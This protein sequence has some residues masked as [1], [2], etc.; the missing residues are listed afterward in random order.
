MPFPTPPAGAEQAVQE[1]P[2]VDGVLFDIDETLVDLEQAMGRTLQ[3]IPD[4][5]LDHLS[6]DDW[7]RYKALYTGDPQRHYDRFLAGELTFEE[8][9]V[10][11]I[12]HA[13]AG[14][15]REPFLGHTADAWV[16]AYEQTLPLHFRAYDDVVPLL[17]ELDAR[18]IPYGAVSNNVHDYQRAKLDRA[19]LNRISVLV[20]IDAVGVAKPEP[21]IY[22][23][24]ARLI[25]TAPERTLYVGDNRLIDA[26]GA[27]SAGLVGVWLDR[28]GMRGE[29]GTE[30]AREPSVVPVETPEKAGNPAGPGSAEEALEVPRIAD[31]TAVLQFLPSVR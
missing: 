10:H 9:R 11:R 18:G 22:L 17:D 30:S 14:F 28:T 12:R 26:V 25:G 3:A 24:G 31:L 16:R 19:G 21:G 6:D 20:G 8:Q 7:V 29:P 2:G 15:T 5:A 23:E 4:P 1:S 27:R 13:R